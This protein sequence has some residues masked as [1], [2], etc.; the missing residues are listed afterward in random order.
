MDDGGHALTPSGFS[1][2]LRREIEGNSSAEPVWTVLM[3]FGYRLG[4][5]PASYAAPAAAAA[6]AAGDGGLAPILPPGSYGLHLKAVDVRDP[7]TGKPVAVDA[8][9][10]HVL[11]RPAGVFDRLA[12]P[13]TADALRSAANTGLGFIAGLFR[14]YQDP[15]RPGE[16]MTREGLDAVF[17]VTPSRCHPF[18]PA[19]PF[20]V[21]HGDGGLIG[22][23]AWLHL[24]TMLAATQPA[25]ALS[26]LYELGYASLRS[27]GV[28]RLDF[29]P[30]PA[31]TVC[32]TRDAAARRRAVSSAG[33]ASV[34]ADDV[35]GEVGRVAVLGSSGAG[36][37]VAILH[38]LNRQM[39]R[40]YSTKVAAE[41][42]A[43]AA[44]A[45]A[46]A[47]A[48][49]GAQ[50]PTARGLHTRPTTAPTHYVLEAPPPPKS[51]ASATGDDTAVSLDLPPEPK[52]LVVTVR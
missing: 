21:E 47:P 43:A 30:L 52:T 26:A 34:Y 41:R 42:A 10:R 44:A 23:K 4:E 7:A 2:F 16:V 11:S 38:A 31:L 36:K 18:G 19:F 9:C 27:G 15:G 50:T 39:L 14:R 6:A 22:W 13:G 1:A 37:T 8:R 40:E 3:R 35:C 25:R 12:Y 45:G 48:D 24:W 17:A 33:A 28:A 5:V 51:A 49:G 32:P 20:V 29:N 46:E